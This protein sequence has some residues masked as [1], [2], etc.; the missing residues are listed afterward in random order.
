MQ[1][2][3]KL[4]FFDIDGTLITDDTR[5]ILPESTK[6]AIRRTRELGNMTF[7][8]TGRVIGNIDGFIR[9]AG[10]DGY[11]CGCGTYIQYQDNV[12][13][14]KTLTKE[15]CDEIAMMARKCRVY[16]LYEG[17][18]TTGIDKTLPITGALLELKHYFEEVRKVPFVGVGEEGFIFDK[19]AGWYDEESELETFKEY[20]TKEFD[21]IHRGEGFFE[22]V[23][24]G[25]SKATGIQFLCDYFGVSL[26]DCYAFGD[27][28][29]D[30]P[31]LS[32]VSHSVAMGES[33]E[34]LKKQVEYVTT[35]VL[36][37]GILNAMK[38]YG[39]C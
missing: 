37:D 14:H 17:A 28:N 7:I 26:E 4:L 33:N 16:N 22:I 29:N 23:P 15:T 32:Y 11:V 39:L 31:M 6:E 3:K 9:E 2:K 13:L 35:G 25:Y 38:H 12:L 21:Y 34:E 1:S 10:F 24:K 36:E 27:S 5:R 20:I 8:N 19:F 18:V 30:L